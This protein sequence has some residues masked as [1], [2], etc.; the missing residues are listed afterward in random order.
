[1]ASNPSGTKV[2]ELHRRVGRNL[3]RFQEIEQSLRG[4]LPYIHPDG[5]KHGVDAMQAYQRAKL[6]GTPLGILIGQFKESL[7]GIPEFWESG[8]DR[9]LKERNDL[10]HHF[11]KNSRFD[12]LLPSG[13]DEALVYLDEQYHNTAEW[14]G[15]IRTHSLIVLLLLMEANPK[16]AAEFGHLREQLIAQLPPSL[17]V[18]NQSEPAKTSWATTRIV[19]LLKIAEAN[20]ESVDGMTL[21]SRAGRFIKS[22][23]PDTTAKEYG[24]KTLREILEVS[25]LFE[26]VVAAD[27]STVMYRSVDRDGGGQ[28]KFEPSGLNFSLV[29]NE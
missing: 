18:I 29:R 12:L 14:A 16:L 5:S 6:D 28:T 2:D 8:L 20:T 11:H 25:G 26:V 7:D 17:E 23:S 27:Q 22:Q 19:K 15:I 13:L 1:M 9:L 3:L 4:M 10:V 21:L 24:L